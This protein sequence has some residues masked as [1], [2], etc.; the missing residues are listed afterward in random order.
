MVKNEVDH[1]DNKLIKVT[2]NYDKQIND[3]MASFEDLKK[4]RLEKQNE[5]S[6]IYNLEKLKIYNEQE[7]IKSEVLNIEAQ[8]Q[9]EIDDYITFNTF[10][11]NKALSELRKSFEDEIDAL[12][13]II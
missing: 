11:M 7:K 5:L 12:D 3:Q 1:L 10:E 6:K 2:Q 13:G 9:K 4:R 8:M